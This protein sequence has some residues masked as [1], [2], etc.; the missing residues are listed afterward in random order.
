MTYTHWLD[1]QQDMYTLVVY[2]LAGYTTRHI[3]TG[4]IHT[5]L[6]YN[7]TYTHWLYTHWLDIQQYIYT[8]AV[9]TLARYITRHIHRVGQNRIY[10]PYM[11]VYLVVFLPKI[12]YIYRIYMVLANSTYTHWLYTHW[13]DIQQDIYT[14]AVYTTRFLNASRLLPHMPYTAYAN[15][16][17]GVFLQKDNLE[18]GQE[19]PSQQQLLFRA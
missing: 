11:T 14:L 2:A 3:H 12:P 18:G 13:L 9:Y 4:C 10:T 17:R 6:I 19:S 5:G 15:R 8:L 1:T 7:K 16:S